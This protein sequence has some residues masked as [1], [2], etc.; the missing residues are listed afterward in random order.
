MN[1]GIIGSG[2]VGST[3]GEMWAK[4]GHQVMF[5]FS[6][7]PERLRALADKIGTNATSG[8]PAE[9]ANFADVILFAPNFW[10]AETA[11]AQAGSLAGKIVIDTTN[12]YRWSQ[13]DYKSAAFE[14][15][16]SGLR[17]PKA[18]TCLFMLLDCASLLARVL[19]MMVVQA[20]QRS[21]LD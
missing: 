3:L 8:S 1:I 21:R 6:R 16:C 15:L 18:L 14:V 12:P 2:N 11:I 19:G 20:G 17:D 5:S 4:A 9:A 13:E 10:S 7:D